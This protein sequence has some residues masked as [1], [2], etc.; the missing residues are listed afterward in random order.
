MFAKIA[1]SV[2][3][4]YL[5]ELRQGGSGNPR[6][7]TRLRRARRFLLRLGDPDVTAWLDGFAFQTPFSSNIILSH[8]ELPFYDSVL[9][10]LARVV[11]AARGGLVMLDIGANIGAATYLVSRETSGRFLCVEANPRFQASLTHNLAQIPQSRARFVALTDEKRRTAVKHN[12]AEGNSNI[13]PCAQGGEWLEFVTLDQLLDGEP[14]YRAPHLVKIDTEGFELRILRGATR[15]LAA[16]RPVLFF[17]FFPA[18]IRREGGDPDALFTLLQEHGYARFD[19]YDGAGNPLTQA[20]GGQKEL[21]RSLRLYCD[22][23]RSFFDVVAFPAAD[24]A[25]SRSFEASELDFFDKSLH[26]DSPIHPP[27]E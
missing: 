22:L 13:E 14:D 1:Q 10:R 25:L 20:D 21:L 16:H 27:H 11:R 24:A 5:A 12:Y 19:F 6:R 15:L 9:P 4:A 7:R 18:F 26:P 3:R 17:E 2:Y 23:R 8:F